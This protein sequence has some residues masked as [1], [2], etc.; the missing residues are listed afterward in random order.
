MFV[1]GQDSSVS[2]AT[3]YGLDGPGIEFRWVRDFP[4]PFRPSRCAMGT[5]SFPAIKWRGCGVDHPPLSRT[6]VKE[7]VEL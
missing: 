5:G 2:I 4:H 7:R 3:R 6:D 1:G